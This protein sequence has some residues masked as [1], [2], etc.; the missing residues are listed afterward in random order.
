MP[1][2]GLAEGFS[3]IAFSET[4]SVRS[5]NAKRYCKGPQSAVERD[6]SHH[7]SMPNDPIALHGGIASGTK[8]LL[9]CPNFS[10][11]IWP[12]VLAYFFPNPLLS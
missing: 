9:F 3:G 6:E 4:H 8:L 7:Q 1:E 12:S 2:M 10:V 11:P 5:S